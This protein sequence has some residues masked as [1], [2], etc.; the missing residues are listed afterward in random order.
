MDAAMDHL[1]AR[2]TKVACLTSRGSLQ[3]LEPRTIRAYL[4]GLQRAGTRVPRGLCGH[5]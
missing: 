5:L 4:A 3:L 2:H 1:T